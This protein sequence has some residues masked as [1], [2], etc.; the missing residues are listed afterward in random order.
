MEETRH[1]PQRQPLRRRGT[2]LLL[3]LLSLLVAAAVFIKTGPHPLHQPALSPVAATPSGVRPNLLVIMVDDRVVF[4]VFGG[5][6]RILEH[7]VIRN[8]LG[9][10]QSWGEHMP[11]IVR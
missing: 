8:P 9:P 4:T 11:S 1:G 2:V 6:P 7:E 10:L 5:Q 3:S